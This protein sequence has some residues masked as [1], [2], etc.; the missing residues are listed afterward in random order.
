S[1][2]PTQVKL[3][4]DRQGKLGQLAVLGR[5]VDVGTDSAEDC[6]DLLRSL[7]V[8]EKGPGVRTVAPIAVLCGLSS[9]G[10]VGDDH[11]LCVVQLGQPPLERNGSAGTERAPKLVGKRV[12]T[13][14]I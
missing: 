5:L 3:P 8:F 4:D 7:D 12:V 11:A 14:G 9:L 1:H 13:T 10:G 2:L 6:P